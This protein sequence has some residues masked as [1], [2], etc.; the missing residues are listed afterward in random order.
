MVFWVDLF[1]VELCEKMFKLYLNGR[2]YFLGYIKKVMEVVFGMGFDDIF[3]EF[4][5]ELIGCGV[6]V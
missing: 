5:E 2:L 1:F 4:D 6:I 3:E